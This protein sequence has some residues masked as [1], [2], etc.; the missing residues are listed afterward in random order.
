MAVPIM[1]RNTSRALFA[2][3]IAVA[4]VGTTSCRKDRPIGG[5]GMGELELMVQASWGEEPFTVGTPRVNITNY[6]VLVDMLRLYLAEIELTGAS[7]ER[8]SEIELF[9][10]GVAPQVR[11]YQVPA[12]TWSGLR[13]GIGVPSELNFSDPALYAQGHPL[14]VSNGTYWTWT[15]GYR[16]VIFDGRYDV[17]P[18]GTGMVLPV[19]SI[20]PGLDTCYT[21]VQRNAAQPI[22]VRAGETTQLAVK[23]DVSRFFH[24][25]SDT[26]DL[27]VD[28]Q[29]HGDNIQLATRFM[30]LVSRACTL[31]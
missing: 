6:R 22:V 30:E 25:P 21:L 4:M 20:H 23:F 1:E 10:L 7:T 27:A 14:S 24:S 17:D 26:L 18:E 13:M 11:R 28:N 9:S 31:E 29:A 19:F 3:L 12:G 5:Q 16:F 15:T 8:L 2:L